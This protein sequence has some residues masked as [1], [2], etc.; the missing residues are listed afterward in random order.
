[1]TTA[2]DRVRAHTAEDVNQR[3]DEQAQRRVENAVR[4]RPEVLGRRISE[5]EAE[6]DMERWLEMNASAL[7]LGG[8]VLGLLVNKKFFALPCIVLPFLLLHA[9][10]AGAPQFRF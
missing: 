4:L 7:A 2:D 1:M 8:T 6:W 5:L 9:V 3:I 10:K